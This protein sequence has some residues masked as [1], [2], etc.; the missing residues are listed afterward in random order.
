MAHDLPF[1]QPKEFYDKLSA[2]DLKDYVAIGSEDR[3]KSYFL[4]MVLGCYCAADYLASRPDWDGRT[5]VVIGT[6]Q[7]GY[8]AF[9]TAGLHPKITAML[10]NVPAGCDS[11]AKQAGRAA[12]WPYWE[13]K[14]YGG[15]DVKKVMETSRYYDAVNFARRVKCPALV[16]M[17]LIDESCPPAGVLAAYNVLQGKKERLVLPLSNHHGDRGAQNPYWSRSEQWLAALAKGKEPAAATEKK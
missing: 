11:T 3:E 4:R 6:S 1:D 15:R 5:L 16:S 9:V 13:S 14:G 10:A 17:G 8:Q 12:G 2:G 7:G